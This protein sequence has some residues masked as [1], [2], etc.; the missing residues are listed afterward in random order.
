MIVDN[1]YNNNSKRKLILNNMR[2]RSVLSLKASL[3][4]C[5]DF[6][7]I[8]AEYKKKSPSGFNNIANSDMLK[9]FNLIRDN[10]AGISILTEP[11]YFNGNP[12]DAISVQCYNKP[13]LIK[14]FI[15]NMDMIKSSYMI[16][17]DVYLLIADFLEYSKIR[18]LV[19]YGKSLG[20]E[21]LVEVHD[22]NRIENIYNDENVLI[23]YNRR[24][25]KTLKMEDE[26]GE[27]YDKLRSFGSPLILESGISV[28][29]AK[30][31]NL[32]KY[33]GLLIG[34]A[35]LSGENINKLKD[36]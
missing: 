24:N 27:I 3:K 18:E 25:L 31:L 29:N 22:K 5:R 34:T 28:D 20:M 6:P 33:D 17:G 23:G 26:S 14:D 32:K 36:D 1:I 2:E 16:G 9:Y 7:G 8:I 21:A 13:I 35:L 4:D 12:L 10:I 15:S 11:Q 19:K 30:T